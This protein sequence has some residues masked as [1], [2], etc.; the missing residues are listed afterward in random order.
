MGNIKS[1]IPVVTLT[2]GIVLQ[3]VSV[4]F[5]I[6]S[7]SGNTNG[8]YFILLFS[9]LMFMLVFGLMSTIMTIYKKNNKIKYTELNKSYL[10]IGFICCLNGIFIVYSSPIDRT[11]PVLFLVISNIGIFYGMLLTK[12]F[13]KSKNYLKYFSKKPVSAL[14]LM[15]TA[16]T[17][18]ILGR[19]LYEASNDSFKL[20]SIFWICMSLV[21]YFFNSSSSISQEIYFGKTIP[22]CETP[23]FKIK[24]NITMLFYVNTFQFI[25]MVLFFWVDIIPLFGYSTPS[26][27][28]ENLQNSTLC[29]LGN[30]D[31]DSD[32]ALWGI[33]F[34]IGYIITN[35]SLAII[36]A[37]SANFAIYSA[38]ISVPITA[39]VFFITGVGVSSTPIWFA[40]PAVILE[41][42][43]ITIW[44]KWENSEK[45][46]HKKQ[47][48]DIEMNEP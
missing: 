33:V 5:W 16:M 43:S 1:N 45:D 12:K 28:L 29:F 17:I 42:I 26:N 48:K 39:S 8:P 30:N 13:I 22:L 32:V 38:V 15:I 37:Y 3:R 25:F 47:P 40:I 14:S 9:T 7:F 10:T 34:V 2:I 27:F 6:K 41:I 19:I 31:C 23:Y 44:K 18:M 36:C 24:N 20:I 46:K 35:I 21:G 11:P 4:P